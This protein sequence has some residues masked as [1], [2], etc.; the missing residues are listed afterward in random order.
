MDVGQLSSCTI[1]GL[2]MDAVQKANSGHPGAPMG[3][4]DMAVV[5]W[6]R[7]VKYDP[8]DPDWPDRDRVILSNGHGSM[9]LYSMLHLTG[10]ALSV[11]DLK[12]FRQ[13]GS[14][15][16][17]HPE[18]G[19]APGIE[20][21]TGP[22]GQGFA[23]GLG[24]A[25]AERWL[26]GR[27]GDDLVDHYTWVLCGDGCLMEGISHEAASLAG[28]LGLGRLI[29]LYDDNSI[30]IDGSTDK[31]FSEDVGARFEA[32][33]WQVL[34]CDGHDQ[35]AIAAAIVEAKASPEKPTLICCKTIIGNGA[36]NLQG[37]AKTHGAPLG[38]DEIRAA[39]IGM[40]FDPEV[41]F[42]I[43]TEV[44]EHFRKNDEA[45][46]TDRMSWEK[47]L[48]SSA[49]R[50]QWDSFHAAPDLDSIEFPVF[51]G[52][53]IATRKSNQKVLDAIAPQLGQLVGGSADLTGSNGSYQADGGDVGRL[54]FAGRNL[55]FGVREHGMAA[56]CNGIAL[57]SGMIPYCATFLTFHDYMRPSV[58]LSALMGLQV[59]Y[60]YTHDSVW[61]GEDGPTHQPVEQIQAMRSMINV[62]VVRPADANESA[63]AWKLALARKD[64]PTALCLT[65]QGLVTL[66]RNVYG[67]ASGTQRGG[68]VLIDTAG[69]PDVVLIGTGSEVELAL[70]ARDALAAEGIGARVVSMPCV[71]LYLEQD[72]GYRNDVLPQGT[73]RVS[74]EAGVTF[75][76]A[77][78]VGSNGASVGIDRYGASAPGAVVADKLGMNVANV[79]AT[80]KRVV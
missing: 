7:F 58:R 52:G 36:P 5:L 15:T 62:W 19:E 3:M 56:M 18:Y 78:I 50:A 35:E 14:R 60:V 39:K 17:G 51:E 33:R 67:D 73:P 26:N 69:A 79:V 31:A 59:V 63:E 48:E 8:S 41:D 61:L 13:W 10:T 66:D 75:G 54:D 2:A 37:T 29:V 38:A 72:D 76:W 43:P 22:L 9:L 11:D 34:R 32:Y 57:H 53:S 47:R 65:R 6:S 30:T 68:Y 1:K 4:A 55:F 80:V 77:G 24:M 12:D 42:A 45:R 49:H 27:F 20:T 23:N 44:V 21:T 74:I 40:G 64:G 70:S 28:H 25:F 46:K 71:E 16:A